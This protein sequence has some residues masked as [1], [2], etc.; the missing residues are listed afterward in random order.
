MLGEHGWSE[1]IGVLNAISECNMTCPFFKS[2]AMTSY[3]PSCLVRE[4][5]EKDLRRYFNLFILGEDGMRAEIMGKLFNLG[6]MTDDKNPQDLIKYLEQLLK[7]NRQVYTDRKV[8]NNL[9]DE[10]FRIEVTSNGFGHKQIPA[11]IKNELEDPESL[12]K[13]PN[14]DKILNDHA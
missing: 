6:A 13:S 3:A 8:T 1:F 11:I 9:V 5:C 10:E 12:L 7:V 4:M 2:C 14:L